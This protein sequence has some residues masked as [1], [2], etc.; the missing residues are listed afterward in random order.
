[1]EVT[2]T[3]TVLALEPLILNGCIQ[4][5]LICFV[6]LDR[7]PHQAASQPMLPAISLKAAHLVSEEQLSGYSREVHTEFQSD[8]E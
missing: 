3:A 8:V 6:G 2:S 4:A 7:K 1:M 5:G